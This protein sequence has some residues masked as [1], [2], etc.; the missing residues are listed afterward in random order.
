DAFE[1]FLKRYPNHELAQQAKAALREMDEEAKHPNRKSKNEIASTKKRE[2]PREDADEEEPSS[3][4]LKT[5]SSKHKGL[6]RIT[7]LRYWSTPDY[8]RIAIDLE[9][10]VKYE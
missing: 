3:A 5:V 8:T 1:E 7:S 6:L 4:P 9:D 10:E 2:T